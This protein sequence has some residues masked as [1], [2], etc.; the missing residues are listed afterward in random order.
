LLNS[1]AAVTDEGDDD[2][3][4][5]R[6]SKPKSCNSSLVADVDVEGTDVLSERASS[7]AADDDDEEL[8]S[9]DDVTAMAPTGSPAFGRACQNTANTW[10]CQLIFCIFRTYFR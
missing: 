9:A 5:V 8:T 6:C 2:E 1:A 4:D 10:V 7:N 3:D